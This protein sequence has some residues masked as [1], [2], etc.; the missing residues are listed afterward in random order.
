M[1]DAWAALGSRRRTLAR[2][3]YAR[4]QATPGYRCPKCRQPIDWGLTW[5]DPM[6]RTVGHQHE[7]QDGGA[8]LDLDNCW[9][10]HLHCNSRAGATRRH[11]RERQ[12]RARPSTIIAIDPHTL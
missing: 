1:A 3:V 2:Q 8:I 9:T 12:A 7:L 5:P 4:D 10:E 6:A 11:Q